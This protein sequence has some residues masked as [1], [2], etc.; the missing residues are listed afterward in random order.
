[1]QRGPFRAIVSKAP[2]GLVQ[3]NHEGSR[4]ANH[5]PK[6]EQSPAGRRYNQIRRRLPQPIKT[7]RQWRIVSKRRYACRRW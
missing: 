2:H 1:L 5:V 7:S 3:P 6:L 4:A